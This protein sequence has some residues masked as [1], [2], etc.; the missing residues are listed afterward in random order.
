MKKKILFLIPALLGMFLSSCGGG[1]GSSSGGGGGGNPPKQDFVGVSF[2]SATYTYD[3]NSH[4]LGEVTGAP[5]NT[6]ITYEIDNES[7]TTTLATI[8]DLI[9]CE[10]LSEKI[11]SINE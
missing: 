4:I 11:T 6:T 7:L 9:A 5:E 8:D 1:G 2:Q 10:I 3:G